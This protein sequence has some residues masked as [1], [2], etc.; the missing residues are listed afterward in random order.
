VMNMNTI[1]HAVSTANRRAEA[2][3]LSAWATSAIWVGTL[4]FSLALVVSSRC[5]RLAITKMWAT[6]ALSVAN[7]QLRVCGAE[8]LDRPPFIFVINHTSHFDVPVLLAAIPCA[9]RFMADDTLFSLSI[10]GKRLRGLGHIPVPLRRS[11]IQRATSVRT[12]LAALQEGMSIIIFPEGGRTRRGVS[13]FHHGA[14]YLAARSGRPLVPVAL[15]GTRSVMPFGAATIR[16]GSS[17]QVLIAEFIT[18]SLSTAESWR[19][20]TALV[21]DRVAHLVNGTD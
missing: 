3:F 7:V 20:I 14:T 11:P 15:R 17:V 13:D 5:R 1:T 6:F 12:A 10:I 18:V 21:R 4:A 9:A 8:R 16:S 2:L 19:S